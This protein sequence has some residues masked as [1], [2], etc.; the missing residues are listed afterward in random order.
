[1][2]I[3]LNHDLRHTAVALAVAAGAHPKSIQ[4]RLGHSS[5]AMTLDR[6]G[7]LLEGLDADVATRLEGLW[8]ATRKQRRGF[9][10]D[11]GEG[12]PEDPGQTTGQKNS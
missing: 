10:A 12:R 4:A 5:V 11:S 3:G 1:M 9:S 8:K 2:G 7:H 6:Y